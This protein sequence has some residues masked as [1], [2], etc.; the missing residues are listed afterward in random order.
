MKKLY[1]SNRQG[2]AHITNRN[3][4]QFKSVSMRTIL[5]FMLTV[6]TVGVWG[7]TTQTFSTPG[8]SNF[9]VPAGVT[10]ITVECWGAGGGG[11]GSNSNGAGGSGG[12]GGGYATSV[13]S[14]SPGDIV[15][16][17]VG[18][19][20]TAG[21][22]NIGDGGNGG[23][24]SVLG[25]TANGGTGGIRNAGTVGSGGIASGG[26][27]NTTGNNGGA[28]GASGGNGGAGANG[29]A[30][31]T[32]G[33]NAVGG[34][35]T[36]PGGGGGG[37]ERGGGNRAGGS[38]ANGQ[39]SFTYTIP[40]IYYSKGSGTGVATTFSNWTTNT[41]GTGSIPSS[42]TAANQMFVVQSGHTMTIPSGGWV[43]SGTNTSVMVNSGGTL[44]CTGNITGTS[45]AFILSSG[46]F[47][48]TPNAAGITT[49]GATG[50]I[51]VTGTRTF[52][53]GANYTYNSTS[54]QATGNGLPATISGS[55]T[56]NNNAGVTLSQATNVSG[57]FTPTAGALTTAVN[58]TL[59]GTTA[60]GTS[61]SINATAG[62]VTYSGASALNIVP[63]TY[64]NLTLASAVDYS[65]CGAVT[66]GNTLAF[67]TNG[68]TLNTGYNLTLNGATV[69]NPTYGSINATAG[70]VSY[71]NASNTSLLKGTYFNINTGTGAKSLQ[72]DVLVNNTF[73]WNAANLTLGAYNLTLGATSSISSSAAF[74]A[75][76]M[77]ICNG[78]TNT[79]SLIKQST[80]ASG[81]ATTYPVGSGTV[82][83]PLVIA[84]LSGTVAGTASLS[85]NTVP[86][87]YGTG[88]AIAT[89]LNRYWTLATTN[90]T[91]PVANVSFTYAD[92][93]EKS[94]AANYKGAFCLGTDWDYDNT[95]SIA[96]NLITN[97]GTS[98]LNGVWTARVP[99]TTYYSYQSGA[100]T[101]A[102]TWTTDPSGTLSVNPAVPSSS[103]NVVILNG[104]T[105]TASTSGQTVSTLQI[106]EGGILDI[107]S[108]TTHSFGTV[109]GQGK[110][111][112]STATFPTGTFTDFVSAGG[113]TVEYYNSANFNFSQL[114]YNNLIINLNTASLFANIT[115]TGFTVNGNLT[116]TKGILRHG[117][118]SDATSVSSTVL[119]DVYV[120]AGQQIVNN[121]GN[122]LNSL[123]VGGDF[124]IDGTVDFWEGTTTD[125]TGANYASNGK[126][127]VVFN[128]A[129]ADQSLL[130]NGSSEFYR[131]EIDKGSDQTYVLN[132][133]ASNSSNFRLYGQNSQ[134]QSGT[135][136]S[137]TN[138]NALGLLAG[139]VRLG[140]NI[141]L[142][143]IATSSTYAIDEDARLWLDGATVTFSDAAIPADGTALL[144]YGGLKISAGTILTDNSKQGIVM[145]TSASFAME[146]GTVNTECVRTSYAS[147]THRGSFSMS[148]GTLTIRG[149]GL[150]NLGGMNVYSSFTLPY[151]DNV[152]N[153][154]G[155]T[156]NVLSPNP[157]TGG[158]GS[159][160]SVLIGANP[161]NAKI[162]GGTFNITIP[163]GSNAYINST[164][165]FWD[166]NITGTNA[167]NSAQITA[168]A[169]NA[170][171][172]AIAAQPLVVYNN[173]TLAN[174]S[175]LNANGSN[176]IVGSNYTI[177][178]SATYT[179]GTNTT[180]FN[181]S[182]A[183]TF[184]KQG[185][186][187]LNNLTLSG[188]SSL[189]LTNANAATPIVAN[190]NLTI[191]TGCTLIDNGRILELNG[192]TG[193]TITNNGTHYKPATGAGS[194][195]LTGTTAQTITGDGNGSFNNLT[196]YKTGGTVTLASDMAITG[197]LRL[198]GTTAGAW[199]RL[200]IGVN[201][202][203]LGAETVVYSALTGTT[204]TFD[205]TRMIYTS[206]LMS[207]GGVSKTFSNTNTFVYP[208]GFYNS[209]NTTYYYAPG[210]INFTSAPSTYG[211]ITSRPVNARHYLAQ[212]SANSLTMY[213]KT[214]SEGFSGITTSS[215]KQVYK[216]NTYHV[217]G[218]E[219][220]YIP[221]VYTYG[222]DWTTY[223]DFNLVDDANNTVTFTTNDAN[224]DYTVGEPAAFGAI[225]ARYSVV[226][227]G[228]W[229]N[230]S[231]W[232]VTR[233]GTGGASVPTAATLVYIVDGST[234]TT[235]A[236]SAV[237]GGLF[238]E[239]GATLNLGTTNGHNFAAI[240]DNDV[241]G[242][243]T[244][245]IGSTGYFPRGDF[246]NFIGEDGGT[247]EYYTSSGATAITI[248]T[249]SD[250]TGLALTTYKNLS[251]N[252]TSGTGHSITL[253]ATNVTVLGDMTISGNGVATNSGVRTPA[254]TGRTY[255]INGNVNINSGI[256][257]Y[258]NAV[259]HTINILGN[260]TIAT[261][262]K[263]GVANT[264][265]TN[266]ALNLYGSLT[267]NGTF[268]MNNTGCVP[269][270]F[271]G[272][273]DANIEGS[274]SGTSY[275][276]Y[277]LTC[278]KG[279]DTTPVLWLKANVTTGF[280][281]PFLTLLNGT[282]RVD[283]P[284][285]TIATTSAFDIPATACFSVNSGTATIGTTNNAGDVSLAGK[286]EVLG[287]T[288]NIGSTT[289]YNNDIEYVAA[290]TPTIWV[291]GGALNVR[292]QIRRGT[293]TT[294]GALNY[295][296]R[297]GDVT[298][299]GQAP[300]NTR[301]RLEIT[302]DGSLFEM[303]DGNLT[304][305]TASGTTF[306][307]LYLRPATYNVTGGTINLGNASTTANS[308]FGVVSSTPLWNLNVGTASVAQT[309]TLEVSPLTVLNLLSINSNS[310]FDANG[311]DVTINGN[312]T[313]SNSDA[314]TGI[315][316]GG[317][318]AGSATQTTTFNGAS[319]QT[320]TG[321]GANQ[322]NFANLVL[323][324]GVSVTLASNSNIC[325]NGDF[326][327]NSGLFADGGSNV[328]L[329]GD[330]ENNATHS[331]SLSSGGIELAGSS[332]QTIS[333]N[334][335]GTFGNIKINNAL[336]ANLTD[337]ATING[338]L[339]FT[340]GSLYI[341]DYLLTLGTSA[342][343]GGTPGSTKMIALNG[344]L[345]D[346]G[347]RKYF[348]SGDS[349]A[350]TFP[351][352]VSGK[353]TPATFDFSSNGNSN[354]SINI[355]AVNQL[356]KSITTVPT[357][358]LS[359]FWDIVP[360]GFSSAYSVNYQF[361]YHSDDIKGTE[362]SFIP[363][364]YSV[365][366]NIW[367]SNAPAGTL[368]AT[369]NMLSFSGVSSNLEG[370]YTA[371]DIFTNQPMLY[372]IT[373]G[374]WA[375]SG[376]WST[377]EGG[378]S[379]GCT[380]NG[381][382]VTISSGTTVT[383]AANNASAYS[384]TINGTLNAGTTVYHDLGHVSG[385]G[386][387]V[388]TATADGMYVFPGGEFDGFLDNT[389]STL[390]FT[391]STSGTLPLKPGNVY[392]PYQNVIFSGTGKKYMSAEDMKV[393][394]DL[395]ISS[396]SELNN[397]L[398]NKN[399]T[400]EG[401]WT[402]LNTSANGFVP[403]TGTVTFAGTTGQSVVLSNTENFYNL[404]INNANNVDLTS[405]TAG[406]TV[407]KY[408][409]L[410]KGN[411]VTATSKLI[412]ITNTST[413]AII[414]G[415]STS[416]VDGPLAKS[417]IG[418]Q[419]FAFP[420][421]DN[422]RLGGVALSGTSV[423]GTYTATYFNSSPNNGTSLT[424]PLSAV[425]DNEYWTIG[426]PASAT[427]NVQL[428]WDSQSG[429]TS[430][431]TLRSRLR[432]AGFNGSSWVERGST[433]SGNATDG[434]VATT[435]ASSDNTYTI[436]RIGVTA[437]ITST[438]VSICDNGDIASIPVTLSGTSPWTLTYTTTNGTTT[439]TF[440]QSGITSPNYII[441]LTSDDIGGY[442]ATPYTVSLV[443]VSDATTAGFVTSTTASIEVKLTYKPVITGSNVAGTS[444][445]R[446]YST[447]SHSG[448]SYAWA[449]SGTSGGTIAAATSA[450]TNITFTSTA[451]TYL[452]QLT[453][454][455]S[456]GCSVIT[457]L[458]IVVSAT[459]TPIISPTTANVC[460]NSAQTYTTPAV[461]SHTFAWTVVGGTP[462]SGTGNSITVTWNTV[463]NGSVKVVE[464][465]GGATGSDQ[466]DVIVSAMPVSKTT[467]LSSSTV[468]EGSATTI[469]VNTTENGISYQLR[470]DVD[471]SLIG[472]SI[473]GSGSDITLPT[474][475]LTSANAPYTY[476]VLAYNSGCSLSLPVSGS[477]VVSNPT[478]SLTS[479][480]IDNTVC[481]YES[482]TFTATQ[483]SIALNN[484]DFQIDGISQQSGTTSTYNSVHLLDGQKVKVLGTTANGCIAT[485]N[486]ITM[487]NT[488]TPGL[489]MGT[490]NTD[491]NT[492]TNWCDGNVPTSSTNVTIPNTTKKPII[493]STGNIV[494][495]ELTTNASSSLTLSA[496]GLLTVNSNIT[497]NGNLILVHTNSAPSSFINEGIITGTGSATIQQ[498]LSDNKNWYIGHAMDVNSHAFYTATPL[499]TSI[500]YFD[501]Y[502]TIGKAW[503]AC[504]DNT[505]MQT[506]M[507]G[508]YVNFGV[509]A[510]DKTITQTGTLYAGSLTNQS[511]PLTYGG[512]RWNLVA[513][514]YP[515]FVD[516]KN[517]L[518]DGDNPVLDPATNP[519]WDFSHIEPTV[520][521]RTKEGA[522]Y[523]FL[524][525]NL[526]TN[527]GETGIEDG[528][529]APMQAFWVRA[530]SAGS[531]ESKTT[532]RTQ[533]ISSHSLKASSTTND[534]L[535]II[536][537]N[538]NATSEAIVV[539]RSIGSETNTSF[540]SEKRIDS[541][542]LVPQIY[543]QKSSKNIAINVM[544]EDPTP[545][546]IPL[547]MTVGAK[548][549][550]SITLKASNITEF[551]PDVNVYLRDL[552]TGT[553]T[554]LRQ[555]AEYTFS[556]EAVSAQNRFELF[557]KKSSGQATGTDVN[558]AAE[559]FSIKAFGLGNK[560]I[561]TI[562]DDAFSN[563]A[564]I[565]LYDATGKLISNQTSAA[566]RT[567]IEMTGNT[568]MVIVKVTYK[569][570]TKSFK[571]MR[572]L[573]L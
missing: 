300:Q 114:T 23:S 8:T 179:P 457:T 189:T 479:S 169:T 329:L 473:G 226:A 158:S 32:G 144:L 289:G 506:P 415:S 12:G 316:T 451:G 550:G 571:I 134:T 19:G 291:S 225:P 382:P 138:P 319:A 461:G 320:I 204:Q 283:G 422:G 228:N 266:Y 170:T 482:V 562:T 101:T 337:N 525:F 106:N 532:A 44:I 335:S 293:S 267:N 345:S 265:F 351:I 494:I 500:L 572:S 59:S 254:T 558:D 309:A 178:T 307:D 501:S 536:A 390:E 430:T 195:R 343:I 201:N 15:S 160:F 420:V 214:N 268:D 208:Y 555:S 129:T 459:P 53:T 198:A 551:M 301:A 273:T 358:Y 64:N 440:T 498:T 115:T 404:V 241:T 187:T 442:S 341:D 210:V 231:T 192:S 540:D 486:V 384:V 109:T 414:G 363:Q 505:D 485:S 143:S 330:V 240:P 310:V 275:E 528:L 290:G 435:T 74:S 353:Y 481:P 340:T 68:A 352:G 219:S 453:E 548:G 202:L 545:Y 527:V 174:T 538:A 60:C 510:G 146:G 35:G 2:N 96:S 125:Y 54:A 328:V 157:I 111:K 368:D 439:K 356:H 183:Q 173:L 185:S 379:C 367:Y 235:T 103:S 444:E 6:I 233:G 47:L 127:D 141:V 299:M 11:G 130:C 142:A 79:G 302:N 406:L 561:V 407:S 270:S 205:A 263:F 212:G 133:D 318:R 408:L 150:P 443:S 55:L 137:L 80:T 255:T 113:G 238:I 292:G 491:W 483:G 40:T 324:P 7:Q 247:V 428:R 541:P 90:L 252:T 27:T 460:V 168:Y 163:A 123:S 120:A 445:V 148:D 487:A 121:T 242:S 495:N 377:T 232:S 77:I 94:T 99:V 117:S 66:V 375:T 499:P 342:T 245:R 75:T 503:V 281:N 62:T 50:S 67:S 284:T 135:S 13:F 167:A 412:T 190:G 217:A 462:T 383:L 523:K 249:T 361:K 100:W 250:V 509:G 73:T 559:T 418:G 108:I 71:A 140:E 364:R 1:A 295:V 489:W 259:A 98:K 294:S 197:E 344:S 63:G 10:S 48:S 534:V 211:T 271:K 511:I 393:N 312:L 403:G 394:G 544:P 31:G 126:T 224:G 92:A 200:N 162:T 264:A 278:D 119:G 567:E 315:A 274:S 221:G 563:N 447:T 424:S 434:T 564:I 149:A 87:Y 188:K 346:K 385:P 159:Y 296:Q 14:V 556:T 454:T 530:K 560:A 350:F 72:G 535:R 331:S 553:I 359:Y 93:D 521:L 46:A 517:P 213:W 161:E 518:I 423:T 463:G 303:T 88:G 326:A 33:T 458:S 370:E 520:W 95:I 573:G 81:L 539:F 376:T 436:G 243:G 43:V 49:S 222:S 83:T 360:T 305:Q 549:A 484:Y 24:S 139:T 147:G 466:L 89:D 91:S 78:S 557:F 279:T 102:T 366:E 516:L 84:S 362:S 433:V 69:T 480:D 9:T 136:P 216:Y 493:A 313:N 380:P 371:G 492:N 392:K 471:N 286:L 172:S 39:V 475:N 472:T 239:G 387:L 546:T 425:S 304:I 41:G 508:Y 57:T 25:M 128:N 151:T 338:V 184:D 215:V 327:I 248:P 181:G 244:L 196:L 261:G 37:G 65:Q 257:E 397:T 317:F 258:R 552:S 504:T 176:V 107:G 402:D 58:L 177:G 85:V 236:N 339:T 171:I 478:V 522:A 194:I 38:G 568:Q 336:G 512:D 276:F 456:T 437:S 446:T 514:P 421:G 431:A 396:G 16:Y 507:K 36:I 455:S 165:P 253:P 260:T 61:G 378:S 86:T 256:L 277:S 131:I 373:N 388:L 477:V 97:D 515:A 70:T 334:G 20:G 156:I 432:V 155:G 314:N 502:N 429:Y 405:G 209:G 22:A 145:R 104:R 51:Q 401:D 372:S 152:I 426:R 529:I 3:Y 285:V 282:F 45:S 547:A 4:Y 298:I 164:V 306:N 374:N 30:G 82:Y 369:N 468:C 175:V 218:D 413:S 322:T 191:G 124:T 227:T 182:G 365:S 347:V 18:A 411:F 34:N 450:S 357:N 389:A 354:G 154:S 251:L 452:L 465:N 269:T 311:V 17:T 321:S 229:E 272:T 122:A 333:G 400:I 186:C 416:F 234:V 395:T 223:N 110:L 569:N 497:N 448:S 419:S 488:S 476:N 325:V 288:L 323:N 230:T 118:T 566:K 513:N 166:L 417:I 349:P 565:D 280:T 469:I 391:G 112:L 153:I 332:K 206:G 262:A 490:T 220:L 533:P 399:I 570:Q 543:T 386:R 199:N 427:S 464:T 542:G 28:G 355:I 531:V 287:G 132:I 398:Y 56:I 5:I 524:T 554:D 441:S 526:S 474:S 203:K 449:W 207:D 297:G 26:T 180:I 537:S 467:S 409:Y 237:A 116:V 496:G 410:T 308:N 42:F 21:I 470:N 438:S 348:T 52:S 246:G 519:S 105:V 29:G 193:T 76:H 381:N